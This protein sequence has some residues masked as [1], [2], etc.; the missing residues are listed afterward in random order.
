MSAAAADGFRRR[1]L[2]AG[3]YSEYGGGGGGVPVPLSML[4]LLHFIVVLL[5][6]LVLI[7]IC[8]VV[9]VLFGGIYWEEE[10]SVT[11]VEVKFLVSMFLAC[12]NVQVK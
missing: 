10:F 9:L 12:L 6:V 2:V 5:H 1:R 4:V 7:V 11:P 3:E 8:I